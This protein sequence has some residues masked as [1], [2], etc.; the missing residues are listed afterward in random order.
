MP[1][2]C[3]PRR[4]GKEI[5]AAPEAFIAFDPMALLALRLEPRRISLRGLSVRATIR[6]DWDVRL[7]TADARGGPAE[8]VRLTDALAFIAAVARTGR[9]SGLSALSVRD[10]RL[11]IDDQRVGREVV[12]EPMSATFDAGERG[13]ALL[14]GTVARAGV[15][16]RYQVEAVAQE[17]GARLNLSLVNIPVKVA[18]TLGG[19]DILAASGDSTVAAHGTV[20]VSAAGIARSAAAEARFSP[21]SIAIPSLFEGPWRIAEAGVEAGWTADAPGSARFRGRFSG[22]GGSGAVAGEIRFADGAAGYHSIEGRTEGLRL[23]PLSERDGPVVV[24]DG[25]VALRVPATGGRLIVDR[26]ALRGPDTDIVLSGELARD[27]AGTAAKVQVVT[28]RMPIRTAIRWWPSGMASGGRTW[29]AGAVEGGFLKRLTLRMDLPPPVFAAAMRDEAM[30]PESMRLEG[31]VEDG[32]VRALD[33]LPPIVGISGAGW[34][35]ALR[36]SCRPA[37]ASSSSPAR[38]AASSSA[39]ASSRST[40]WTPGRRTSPSPSG[41]N[42]RPSIWRRWCARRRCGTSS[43]SRST[44]RT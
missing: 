35:D 5:L 6:P 2:T 37:G 12:F 28:G 24:A 23:T 7:S 4:G 42:P 27:A 9:I 29:L 15:V 20:L 3:L 39:R 19:N 16:M 22:D 43:R 26:V 21:G 17:D 31:E 36:P 18:E 44:R 33:G 32:M 14:S 11:V 38:T 10:A 1:T 13:R 30:P 25:A 8:D 41:R 40:G 34:L